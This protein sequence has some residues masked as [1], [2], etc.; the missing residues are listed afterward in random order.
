MAT[1]TFR[2]WVDAGQTV[3]L[4][5]LL[6]NQNPDGTP[7]DR[8]IQFAAINATADGDNT[9]VAAVASKKIRVINYVFSSTAAGVLSVTSGAAGALLAKYTLAVN[10]GDVFRGDVDSPAFETA[11]GQALV[12]N[13]AVGQ[14]I[15]GHLAY[16]TY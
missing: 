16:I 12:F 8:G 2:Q 7:L 1:L 14:D 15:L 11:A 9:V 3:C 5:A 6:S 10:G 4:A 13:N